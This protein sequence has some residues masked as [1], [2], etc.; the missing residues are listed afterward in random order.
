MPDTGN[1]RCVC[2]GC[3]TGVATDTPVECRTNYIIGSGQLC[4][5]CYIKLYLRHEADAGVMTSDEM[6]MLLDWSKKEE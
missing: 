2:C 5:D 1:D 4:K 3:D 6:E